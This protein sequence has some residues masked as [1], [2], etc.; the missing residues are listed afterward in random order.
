MKTRE[1]DEYCI[2]CGDCLSEKKR[3][4]KQKLWSVREEVFEMLKTLFQE[5]VGGNVNLNYLKEKGAV[6]CRKCK[7]NI[8]SIYMQEHR[9]CIK[10]QL[11]YNLNLCMLG[12]NVAAGHKR[13]GLGD[14]GSCN[15]KRFYSNPGDSP[16]VV[17]IV[18][19]LFIGRN[20]IQ[21]A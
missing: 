8:T 11:L 1:M 16:A 5:E 17:A 10:Q 12:Q 15:P 18:F 2:A 7:C 6:I 9:D 13:G 19:I 14:S 21:K 4:V 3:Y 20:R